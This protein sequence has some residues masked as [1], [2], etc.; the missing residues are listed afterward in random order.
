M[1][2][3]QLAL[4][5]FLIPVLALSIPPSGAAVTEPPA[6]V[7]ITGSSRGIGLEFAR[8]YAELGWHVV[9]TC[10]NPADAKELQ[11]IA[12][13]HPN[14]VIERMDITDE[15]EVAALAARYRGQPIDLLVNNAAHLGPRAKQ[16]FGHLDWDLFE[17][18][19]ETNT[20]G[21]MRVTEA[22]VDNVAVSRLKR[23]VTLSS[24]AAS[25]AGLTAAPVQF[26]QYRASKAALNMLMHGVA[27]DVAGRGIVVGLVNPGLVD[28]RGIMKLAPGDP[29][30]DAFVP[31]MPLVRSGALK[32][33]TPA[34][35]V[36]AMIRLIDG[37]TAQQSGKFLNY[38]GQP[39]PW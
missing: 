16:E 11:Q 29:V 28:T 8:Q 31:L 5:A 36:S 27:L 13:A 37:L 38:D 9:A 18:S 26:H 12:A 33:I 22:F 1:T 4:A 17:E 23:I 34:E 3:R 15:E 24:A 39:L 30:P 21:P 35:S 2:V 6:S 14:L 20:V 7:L 32:L 19:F 10:R 25:I